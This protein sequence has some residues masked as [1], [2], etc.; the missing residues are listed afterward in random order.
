[1]QIIV[2]WEIHLIKTQKLGQLVKNSEGTRE[3]DQAVLT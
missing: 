1:M 3:T 2:I